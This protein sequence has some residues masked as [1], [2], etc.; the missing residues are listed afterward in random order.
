MAIKKGQLENTMDTAMFIILLIIGVA[1][2]F[3]SVTSYMLY[4]Q[5]M[6][7]YVDGVWDDEDFISD[8]NKEFTPVVTEKGEI[9]INGKIYT[10]NKS[11]EYT[12]KDH[13]KVGWD[14]FNRELFAL[15]N[16][17]DSVFKN[18]SL[19]VYAC[20]ILF[21]YWLFLLIVYERER[22]HISTT[23]ISDDVLMRKYNPLIA[24]CLEANRDVVHTDIVAVILGLVN[25]KVIDLEI[26]PIDENKNLYKYIL[27]RNRS[28][29]VNIGM[30]EIELYVHSW[31]FGT[32]ISEKTEVDIIERIR[33]L[34]EEDDYNQKLKE[35][36][37]LA[38]KKLSSIGANKNSVPLHVRV[39][40]T[41]IFV[42]VIFICLTVVWFGMVNI[43]V[44]TMEM[45]LLYFAMIL[46]C[47]AM[48]VVIFLTYAG[49]LMFLQA[50]RFAELMLNKLFK[51]ELVR[52]IFLVLL[53]TLT[54][55]LITIYS[56]FS[57]LIIPYEI[58]LCISFL[59]MKTDNLMMQNDDEIL[60]DYNR[61]KVL[62]EKISGYS[63]LSKREIEEITLWEDYMTYA[64]AFG[65]A[66]EVM[67]DTDK[68][69]EKVKP[70]KEYLAKL[71]TDTIDAFFEVNG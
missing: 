13:F 18:N 68:K 7:K 9:I 25:K 64:V 15:D 23:I 8:G 32:G 21:I 10:V 56:K 51:R 65:I 12:F 4:K 61:L 54:L 60:M 14:L 29:E 45:V 53:M 6:E 66:M 62:K 5:D 19:I 69:Y 49:I 59:I 31:F 67:K 50:R 70:D 28:N 30:D 1:I 17:N 55:I 34:A 43:H 16:R 26:V 40:N 44:R 36:K 20:A 46:V 63:L 71:V 3:V 41:F 42:S 11:D 47:Y 39:I 22:K 57:P 37:K 27:K 33:T 2:L 24:G 38:K 58:L 35:L 48:P 52:V